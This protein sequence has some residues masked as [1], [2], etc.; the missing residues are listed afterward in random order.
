MVYLL[1]LLLAM[2]AFGAD[3]LSAASA[4]KTAQ[5]QALLAHGA[6]I[7]SQD[8]NERTPLMLAA[9]HGHADTVKL[10]LSKGAKAD[11]RDRFGWTAF[12][13]A[14]FAD[15]QEVLQAL[16]APEPFRLAV[17]T[18]SIPAQLESSC[19]VGREELPGRVGALHLETAL[20]EEF[21]SYAGA[22]GKGLVKIVRGPAD[23]V[24]AIASFTVVPG[25]A[26]AGGVDNLK[27]SI[28]VRVFRARGRELLFEKSFGGGFKG[29]R[30]QSVNNVAQYG[31]IY[32]A[33]IKPQSAPIYYAVL[34]ALLKMGTA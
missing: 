6:G 15:R 1:L 26:C 5:V 13:L 16:P 22:S 17:L 23:P 21:L 18:E 14:L 27:L 3:L 7:E 11:A 8:K 34:A 33:W 20:L 28:D 25:A 29:L 31:P 4:G 19:F 32:L 12:G 2:P 24:D 30:T 9:Q 10:L